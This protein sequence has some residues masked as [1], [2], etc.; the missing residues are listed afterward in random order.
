M[1]VTDKVE[2]QEGT[3]HITPSFMIPGADG[4][5]DPALMEFSGDTRLVY[6]RC[7]APETASR[8]EIKAGA[9]EMLRDVG[10]YIA[11]YDDYPDT[12]YL[13]ASQWREKVA[14]QIADKFVAARGAEPTTA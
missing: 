4:M 10:R 5:W 2:M 9:L 3:I 6:G 13:T 1:S 7:R 11:G 12:G 14:E 8:D